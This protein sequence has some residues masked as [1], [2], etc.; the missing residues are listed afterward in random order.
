M[1]SSFLRRRLTLTVRVFSS[2]KLSVSHR[3]LH[4]LFTADHLS[5]LLHK[6]QQDAVL[7][8]RQVDGRA[9]VLQRLHVRAQ[10]GAPRRTGTGGC[11]A[12]S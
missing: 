10:D 7:V 9:A 8:F 6:A 1:R 2:T 11:T 5:R 4:Q 3:R 12:K